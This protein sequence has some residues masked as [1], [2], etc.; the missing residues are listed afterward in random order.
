MFD[1]DSARVKHIQK[2]FE[3][4]QAAKI[5][6]KNNMYSDC[7]NRTYYS[8][9]HAMA[10]CLCEYKIES[11]SHKQVIVRFREHYIK[12][13]I[14]NR[15]M[16]EIIT[17]LSENR[18]KSDYSIEYAADYPTAYECLNSAEIFYNNASNYIQGKYGL[19]KI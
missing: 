5:L 14:F 19:G 18:S 9:F 7:L 2:S 15:Q 11:S 17:V 16:S 13:G 3:V 8:C 12:T 4:L 10:A 1:W 6:F